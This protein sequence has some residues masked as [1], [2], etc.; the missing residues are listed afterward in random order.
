MTQ[1]QSEIRIV[2]LGRGFRV[3]CQGVHPPSG[4]CKVVGRKHF[5]SIGLARTFAVMLAAGTDFPII[6]DI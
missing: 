3:D 6:E 4:E 1:P 2:R 5:A